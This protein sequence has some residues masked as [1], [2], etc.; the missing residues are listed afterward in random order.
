[1]STHQ[2]FCIFWPERDR[3]HCHLGGINVGQSQATIHS[4][5]VIAD[6]THHVSVVFYKN[7]EIVGGGYTYCKLDS[8][9]VTFSIPIMTDLTD[10]DRY[11]IFIY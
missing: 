2:H 5:V 6:R 1:M 8:P 3:P 9:D 11:D 10:Y 4:D 7:E